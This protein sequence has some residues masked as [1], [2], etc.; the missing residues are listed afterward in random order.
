MI[1][2]MAL[3]PAVGIGFSVPEGT[4]Q[5][6]VQKGNRDM[7]AIVLRLTDVEMTGGNQRGIDKTTKQAM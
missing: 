5:W 4:Y 7:K 3:P 2:R 6:C 1:R